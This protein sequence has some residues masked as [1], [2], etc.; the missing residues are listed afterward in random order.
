MDVHLANL[1][2][3]NNNGA[4]TLNLIFLG[5]S[6]VAIPYIFNF[7]INSESLGYGLLASLLFGLQ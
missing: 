5:I 6:L 7:K 2:L 1:L 3:T 4:F